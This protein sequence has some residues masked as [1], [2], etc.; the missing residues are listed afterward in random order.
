MKTEINGKRDF[1][2]TPHT[3]THKTVTIFPKYKISN[4]L[5]GG[6]YL[7]FKYND[8]LFFTWGVILVMEYGYL[9]N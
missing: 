4:Y 3:H 7:N 2:H 5:E 6:C 9:I 8:F 1:T